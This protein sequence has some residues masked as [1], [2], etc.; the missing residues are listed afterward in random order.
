LFGSVVLE[1]A[2]GLVFVYAWFSLACSA[3]VEFLESF[4]AQRGKFLAV[5]IE[6]ML[7]AELKSKFYEHGLIRSLST[8]NRLPSYLPLR[9]FATVT[10]DLLGVDAAQFRQQLDVMPGECGATLRA[11][12]K[13]AN[14][15]EQVVIAL[16]QWF[17]S[18]MERCSGWFRRRA[19]WTAFMTALVA[20]SLLNVDSV[21]IASTLYSDTHLRLSV[22]A[23][24]DAEGQVPIVM[25]RVADKC[26]QM[27]NIPVESGT[28]PLG[29]ENSRFASRAQWAERAWTQ[30][31]FWL[32]PVLMKILGLV[33][34]ALAGSL[35]AAFWFDL[36]RRLLASRASLAPMVGS[37]AQLASVSVSSTTR[38]VLSS[39]ASVGGRA[40]GDVTAPPVETAGDATGASGAALGVGTAGT[41]KE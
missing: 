15:Y 10:L 38:G 9:S 40:T 24:A 32:G 37:L 7:G 36:L 41:L 31:A 23:Q 25:R 20:A 29:W 35:G 3:I 2:L 4:R 22:T 27:M 33:V 11:L 19:R 14:S 5:A 16:D 13:H 8:S 6:R 12:T 26:P 1:V 39:T 34:T 30:P 21:E 17:D 18:T 28:L